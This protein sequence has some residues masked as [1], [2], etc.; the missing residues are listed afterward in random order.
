MMQN[1]YLAACAVL[2]V[3]PCVFVWNKV[4]KDGVFGRGALLSISFFASIVLIESFV[5]DATY[6]PLFETVA[7]TVGFAVF[8]VWH[9]WRFH[10]R[11]LKRGRCPP[12]CPQDRRHIR[13]RRFVV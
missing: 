6:N 5:N 2:A 8:L 9:L 4:Y 13:E 1:I 3:V 12:D 10:R 11:V 7:M